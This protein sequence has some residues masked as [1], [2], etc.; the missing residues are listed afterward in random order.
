M[1]LIF[2]CFFLNLSHEHVSVFL[3]LLGEK[4][5]GFTTCFFSGSRAMKKETTVNR[6]LISSEGKYIYI[7]PVFHDGIIQKCA[8]SPL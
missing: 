6:W 1:L 5:R 4:V 7:Y 2:P 8:K 3:F